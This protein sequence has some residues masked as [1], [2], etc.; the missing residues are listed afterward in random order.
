MVKCKRDRKRR[1]PDR[2][3]GRKLKGKIG[4]KQSNSQSMKEREQEIFRP[5]KF[6]AR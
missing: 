3:I 2:K 4:G 5:D 6:S 1:I